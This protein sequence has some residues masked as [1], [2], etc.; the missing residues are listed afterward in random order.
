VRNI[1]TAQLSAFM[2]SK[3]VT[4]LLDAHAEV[5]RNYYLGGLR[6]S[7]IEGGRFCEAAFRILEQVTTGKFT[8][9][10][11][12][13][14]TER[15][16]E[17]LRNTKT[18]SQP[19]SVRLHIPRALRLVYDIRSKRDAAHLA[20]GIDPNQ[21]DATIVVATVDWVLAELV[22]LF[23]KVPP[24]EAHHIV[25]EI[26]ARSAPIVQD[27]AGVLKVL[28]PSLSASDHSLVLLYHRGAKGA[29]LAE[30]SEWVRPSM[31]QNLNRTLNRLA[32]EKDF[33]HKDGQRYWITRLGEQE[34]EKKRLL[35]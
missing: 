18:G 25:D 3:L 29:T 21:Q 17:Q 10:G 12:Q 34:V 19:D 16:I 1:V 32:N 2:D 8:P 31:R 5:K 35:E 26:V 13:I 24:D 7:A 4:E 11:K 9:L 6:L 23:H 33:L 15:L 28:S 20:D 14:D 22:R 30:L 27:F